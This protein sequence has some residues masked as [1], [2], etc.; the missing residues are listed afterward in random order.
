MTGPAGSVGINPE[1]LG[2]SWFVEHRPDGNRVVIEV[3][4]LRRGAVLRL[5]HDRVAELLPTGDALPA[6]VQAV[7]VAFHPGVVVE[8]SV[9]RGA[10]PGRAVN[11]TVAQRRFV[12][13]VR[14]GQFA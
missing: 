2:I 8:R 10:S 12:C 9:D 11:C 7:H 1:S 4:L 3:V 13:A 5:V 6:A 14:G